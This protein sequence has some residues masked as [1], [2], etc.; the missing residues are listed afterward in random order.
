MGKSL[1]IKLQKY[2]KISNPAGYSYICVV[3]KDV[4]ARSDDIPK[5]NAQRTDVIASSDDIRKKY[6]Q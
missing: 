3:K 1:K 6:P 4:I 5:K 2:G